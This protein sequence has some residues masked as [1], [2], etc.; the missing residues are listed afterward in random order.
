[1][2]AKKKLDVYKNNIFCG[3]VGNGDTNRPSYYKY[4]DA[5]WDIPLSYE[6]IR[7]VEPFKET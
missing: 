1:M 2:F 4:A 6:E 3:G 7:I 5:T